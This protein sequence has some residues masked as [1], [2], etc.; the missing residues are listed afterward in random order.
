MVD[1]EL[2]AGLE[3]C[4]IELVRHVPAQRTKLT[5]LLKAKIIKP[6]LSVCTVQ[7]AAGSCNF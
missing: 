7:Y 1:D 3:V 6:I 4:C 2:S 5:S